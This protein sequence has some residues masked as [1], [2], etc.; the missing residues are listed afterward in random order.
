MT[1]MS[2][3]GPVNPAFFLFTISSVYV[4]RCISIFLAYVSADHQAHFRRVVFS[5]A[6][7]PVPN[8]Y[9]CEDSYYDL[10]WWMPR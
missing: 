7:K 10:I 5:D 3:P 4:D 6:A 1:Q 2:G 8:N 9:L